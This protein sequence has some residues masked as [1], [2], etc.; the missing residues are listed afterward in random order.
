MKNKK[1]AVLCIVIA[2]VIAVVANRNIQQPTYSI[3]GVLINRGGHISG[4]IYASEIPP[5][6]EDFCF[7][8]VFNVTDGIAYYIVASE[9]DAS[10][11][12]WTRWFASE[13]VDHDEFPI[14]TRLQNRG[15]AVLIDTDIT[16]YVAP[17]AYMFSFTTILQSSDGRLQPGSGIGLGAE[18]R[19]EGMV[20]SFVLEDDTA[21]IG[22]SVHIKYEPVN[23]AIAQMDANHN[24]L[25]LAEYLPGAIPEAY[26]VMPAT[27]YI[28]VEAHRQSPSGERYITRNLYSRDNNVPHEYFT[29][30]SAGANRVLIRH[31][32]QI[33]W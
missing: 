23:I 6:G 29:T 22:V 18:W 31:I 32:S 14:D 11:A 26:P 15:L 25:I 10:G 30:F 24:L 3:A 5:H 20:H 28:I 12:G 4:H 13:G 9:L 21:S 7:F 2:I 19:T 16:V 27:A 1:L 33:G 8:D 17:V